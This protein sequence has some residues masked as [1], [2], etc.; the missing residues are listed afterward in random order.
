MLAYEENGRLKPGLE[1][2]NVYLQEE[3]ETEHHFEEIIGQSLALKKALRAVE[4]VAPTNANVLIAGETGTGKELMAQAVHNLSPRKDKA[5]ITVNCASIPK[6]LFESEFFGH[7]RGAFTGAQS[8][9]V[10]RFQL[11]DGG[12][13][14]LDEVSEIPVEL[15]SKLLRALQE[16][17]FERIGDEKT[18]KVNVRIIAAT[19][20]RLEEEIQTGRFRRDLY[21]RLS[22]FPIEVPPLRERTEDIP[23]LAEYFSGRACKRFGVVQNP[24]SQSHTRSLQS[25]HWPG[26]IR[27]LQNIVDRMVITSRSATLHCELMTDKRGDRLQVAQVPATS[28]GATMVLSYTQLKQKE[29][30]NVLAALKQKNWKVAGAAGAAEL[31]GVK[32]STLATRMKVLGIQRPC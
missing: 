18:R 8:D 11:A 30:Q 15:Q 32:P 12:T 16:G 20:R 5:L 22:V 29:Y 24:L 17:E 27:E 1:L 23:L 26:N 4:V 9:R 31:L 10:G 25:Y 3:A 19:N 14:F 2:E 21:F 6:E 7:V 13:L 28:C